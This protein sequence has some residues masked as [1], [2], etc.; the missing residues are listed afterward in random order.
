MEAEDFVKAAQLKADKLRTE[1]MENALSLSYGD[2]VRKITGIFSEVAKLIDESL[3]YAPSFL[4]LEYNRR[5]RSPLAEALAKNDL[6]AQVI[7]TAEIIEELMA[8]DERIE[9]A[10]LDGDG[11][12]EK[13]ITVFTQAAVF[14]HM[15]HGVM[16]AMLLED[17]FEDL[18]D[19]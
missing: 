19:E 12:F 2:K 7:L 11:D 17:E 3:E 14:A 8:D 6:Q 10:L 18:G 5:Y 16:E 4:L 13:F 15:A 9:E 1:A